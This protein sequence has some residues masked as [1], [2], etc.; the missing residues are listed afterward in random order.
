MNQKDYSIKINGITQNLKSVTDLNTAIKELDASMSALEKNSASSA[1]VSKAKKQALTEEEAATKKLSDTRKKMEAIESDLYKQQVAAN[2]EL[3]ERT[4]EIARQ[5]AAEKMAADSTTAI[6]MR[7]TDLRKEYNL[8]SAEERNSEEIGGRLLKQVQELDTEYKAL[9]ESTGDF[10]DSVGNYSK[11]LTGLTKLRGHLDMA[12]KSTAQMAAGMAANNEAIS[13]VSAATSSLSA[14]TAQFTGIMALATASQNAYNLLLKEGIVQQKAAAIMDAVRTA[15]I[16]AKEAA[17]AQATKGTIAATIAQKALNIVAAANP[18]VLLALAL[19][20][21]AGA[22]Y[23]FSS[24]TSKAAEEQKTLNELQSI[25]LDGLERESKKLNEAGEVRVK[26]LQNQVAVLTAQ[27]AKIKEIRAVEDFLNRERAANNA[28]QRGFYGEELDALEANRDKLEKFYMLLEKLKKSQARGE[29]KVYVDIDLDGKIEKVKVEDAINS[30]QSSIDNLGR[31]VKIA[32]DLKTEQADLQRELKIQAAA[33]E[34]EDKEAAKAAADRARQRAATELS[35]F[36]AA[37]DAR[38][39]LIE[40]GYERQ[41]AATSKQF[42]R[43]IEDIKIRIKTE[44]ELT[45][46]SKKSL[47]NTIINLEKNKYLE[48]D[49]LEKE[50]AEKELSDLRAMEDAQDMLIKGIS[51]RREADIKI[52]YD[53]QIEDLKNRLETEKD[54]TETSILAINT[55]IISAEKIRERELLESAAQNAQQRADVELNAIEQALSSASLKLADFSKKNGLIDVKKVKEN[56]AASNAALQEYISGL[57][58]YQ[59]SMLEAHRATLSTLK[60]DTVE[61]QQEL[62]KMASAQDSITLKIKKAQAEQVENTKIS[63]RAQLEYYRELFAEIEKYAMLSAGIF[64]QAADTWNMGIQA[65]IDSLSESLEA[66][67]NKYSEVQKKG[68][69]AAKNVE[70][71]EKQMQGASAGTAEALK[72]QLADSARARSEY[73]RQEQQLLKE[74]EKQESE[75]RK[76]EKQIRRNELIGSLGMALANTA[77]GVTKALSLGFPLGIIAGGIIGGL[78]LVQAGIISRQITKLEDGGPI[79]GPSHKDGGVPL[80]MG[81]EA[82]GGEFVVNKKSYS[83]NTGL[84]EFINSAKGPLSPAEIAGFVSDSGQYGPVI[85]ATETANDNI[86]E[87]INAIDFRPVVSVTDIRNVSDNITDVQDLAG[88]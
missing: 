57:M 79:I 68:Q 5:V 61:Y 52:R 48:L 50:R 9:K 27:G 55:M 80:G 45:E 31:T 53:R 34:K 69:D 38:I 76:K 67:S 74:K 40:N 71:I 73:A 26:N 35:I 51:D 77:Q 25:Y 32:V 66:V 20:S 56:A 41:R 86:I 85:N 33:R 62:L 59:N 47:N 22:L 4:R 65:S 39:A 64:G 2:L 43:E 7:L 17:E 84:V 37:E 19:V 58:G 78:G 81:Y 29:N 23:L 75:I 12:S 21:V 88:F 42:E 44:K 63:T 83:G 87:A 72:I 24:R 18:Y 28:R 13:A 14:S 54:L 6:G 8:L 36:R 3:K 1:T 15:Q 10:R 49:K 60:E 46:A 16:K 82:E 30:V 11:A 70:E